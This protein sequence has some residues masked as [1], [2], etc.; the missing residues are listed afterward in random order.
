MI[1]KYPWIF[2]GRGAHTYTLYSCEKYLDI[3]EFFYNFGYILKYKINTL[4]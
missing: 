3:F 1:I 4:S 2:G